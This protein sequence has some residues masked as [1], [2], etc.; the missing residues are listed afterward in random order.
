MTARQL[1]AILVAAGV[2]L[3][4]PVLLWGVPGADSWANDAV[5]SRDALAGVGLWVQ[6]GEFFRYPPGHLL[7][8]ALLCLP[9]VVAAL[10]RCELV[11]GDVGF[12][13][14][15]IAAMVHEPYMVWATVSARLV[16][17]AMAAVLAWTIWSW[18]RRRWGE[19]AGLLGLALSLGHLPLVYY[20]ATSNLDLPGLMWLVLGLHWLDAAIT[21]PT[22]VS[23]SRWRGIGAALAM[24]VATKDQ[25]AAALVLGL[26]LALGLRLWTLRPGAEPEPDLSEA[27]GAASRGPLR[28][29]L[30]RGLGQGAL[31]AAVTYGVAGGLLWNPLGWWRRVQWL[32]GPASQQWHDYA[33]DGAGRLALLGDLARG[34]FDAPWALGLGPW[35][36]IAALVGIVRAAMQPRDERAGALLPL[37]A[38]A[39][40]VVLFN[41]GALRASPRFAL[42]PGVMA[43]MLAAIAGGWL[44]DAAEQA[45]PRLRRLLT[46]L[47]AGWIVS[48][49][50]WQ[51]VRL[52]ATWAHDPR[53]DASAWLRD[54]A[55]PA[56][57][58]EVYAKN[59]QLP[60]LPQIGRAWR[61]DRT[62]VARRNPIEG[63]EERPGPYG[64]IA[65]RDPTFVVL[66]DS[67]SASFLS[68]APT[69]GRARN[70]ET[71]QRSTDADARGHFEALLGGQTPWQQ[72]WIGRYDGWGPF[73]AVRLHNSLAP[74]VRIFARGPGS[75]RATAPA[76][77][78]PE[79]R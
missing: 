44:L 24:A 37:A 53:D 29:A 11:P 7:P 67:H 39:S 10:L 33:A 74:T 70:V 41:L 5:A 63:L 73:A 23:R 72:V 38:G 71:E 42:L 50:A 56:T 65:A 47:L 45:Q 40:F 18:L 14:A 35:L 78:A 25:L 69:A 48:A 64:A 61:I 8:L 22:A 57:S 27:A 68:E 34:V 55:T 9:V 4:L 3:H 54:H 26:P 15:F 75:H 16:T 13:K 62:D 17:I 12:Q 21:A 66:V 43:L 51:Q 20:G 2:V 36:A 1:A 31:A 60:R 28:A 19:R 32:L 59:Y 49:A 6:P 46:V 76:G 52:V 30:V 58:I 77:D 79:R